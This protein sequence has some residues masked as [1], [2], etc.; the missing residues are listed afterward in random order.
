MLPFFLSRLTFRRRVVAGG[1][2]ECVDCLNL[3]ESKG[4]WLPCERVA[5][6]ACLGLFTPC[7]WL[8]YRLQAGR[9]RSGYLTNLCTS[10][11]HP[12]RLSSSSSPFRLVLQPRCGGTFM[13][14]CRRK[15]FFFDF[16]TGCHVLEVRNTTLHVRSSFEPIFLCPSLFPLRPRSFAW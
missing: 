11:S 2:V 7:V 1:F 12:H 16:V 8:A 3:S 14:F 4:N 15:I 13:N 6:S 9:S 5:L 10:L